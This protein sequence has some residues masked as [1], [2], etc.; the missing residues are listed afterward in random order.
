AKRDV[1]LSAFKRSILPGN[2]LV[3]LHV[4]LS[5]RV[6]GR[7]GRLVI[8]CGRHT[9]R[10]HASRCTTGIHTRRVTAMAVQNVYGVLFMTGGANRDNRVTS[11]TLSSIVVCCVIRYPHVFQTLG[12]ITN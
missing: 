9:L 4:S 7:R 11:L 1:C 6:A 12:Y 8:S 10:C 3:W 5:W 2:R